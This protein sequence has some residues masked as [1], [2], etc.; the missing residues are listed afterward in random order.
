MDRMRKGSEGSAKNESQEGKKDV[1]G[2]WGGGGGGGGGWGCLWGLW[3]WGG[4]GG[5]GGVGGCVGV[6]WWGGGGGGLGGVVFFQRGLSKDTSKLVG[7][8]RAANRKSQ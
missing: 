5:G 1:G 6:C 7:D 8:Q 2:G 4:G 3:G